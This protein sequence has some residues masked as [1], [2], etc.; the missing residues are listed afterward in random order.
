MLAP[1]G[2][3]Y[4]NHGPAVWVKMHQLHTS[5]CIDI[6]T[7][8]SC[9]KLD[10]LVHNT[11]ILD[12]LQSHTTIRLN[13]LVQ[14]WRGPKNLRLPK[15][16]TL[17]STCSSESTVRT[18]TLNDSIVLN[19]ACMLSWTL[20]NKITDVKQRKVTYT[21]LKVWIADVKNL[22]TVSSNTTS[23]VIPSDWERALLK[24]DEIAATII[25]LEHTVRQVWGKLV[26]VWVDGVYAIE[27]HSVM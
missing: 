4:Y 21:S 27:Q 26:Q 5:K 9:Q 25:T 3:T 18:Y 10:Q 17:R 15:V 23:L 12:K 16:P 6:P 1:G 20:H 19:T 8:S 14:I 24:T 13:S 11:S 2:T 7:A 22:T